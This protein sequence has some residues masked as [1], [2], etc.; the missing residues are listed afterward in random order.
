[1]KVFS[2][3]GASGQIASLAEDRK[4][5]GVNFGECVPCQNSSTRLLS[6][7]DKLVVVSR[8]LSLAAGNGDPERFREFLAKSKAAKGECESVRDQTDRHR[9]DHANTTGE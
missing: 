1:M 7:V 5:I 8:L 6:A 4:V 9:A 3:P 2:P